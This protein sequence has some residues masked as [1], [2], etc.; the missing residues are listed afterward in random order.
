MKRLSIIRRYL[1]VILIVGLFSY[2][3]F[4][5]ITSPDS[6]PNSCTIFTATSGGNVYFCNN[7]DYFT[8]QMR[9]WFFPASEGKYGKVLYGFTYQH[10]FNPLGGMNDQGLSADENAVP[11]TPL[12]KDPNKSNYIR[13][14]FFTRVLEV[15]ATVNEVID[16]ID[17]YNLVQLEMYPCQVHFADKTGDAAVIGI[18]SDGHIKITRKSGDYLISTNFNLAQGR[19]PCWRYETAEK[20]L[21]VPHAATVDYYKSILKATSQ[22][23]QYPWSTKYSNINDLKNGLLYFFSPHNYDYYVIINLNEEL[24]KGFHSYDILTLISRE[25][26]LPPNIPIIII[27]YLVLGSAIA[28]CMAIWFLKIWPKILKTKKSQKSNSKNTI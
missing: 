26:G 24:S 10:S 25:G 17:D 5:T 16:W 3:F 7:E 2:P 12:K 19:K 27:T 28:D 22:G 14:N 8:S 18:G 15:C 9:M 23:P 21:S 6:T 1:L 20:M 4:F 11:Y 13:N